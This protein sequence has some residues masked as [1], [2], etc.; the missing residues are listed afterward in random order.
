[1]KRLPAS[2]SSMAVAAHVGLPMAVCHGFQRPKHAG[3]G[4][5][6]YGL[7]LAI[8]AILHH[9]RGAFRPPILPDQTGPNIAA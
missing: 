2:K 3:Q 6:E 5:I 9:Y 7:I 8:M 4:I 1:L